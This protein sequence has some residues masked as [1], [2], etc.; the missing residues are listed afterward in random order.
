MGGGRWSMEMW[1]GSHPAII[2]CDVSVEPTILHWRIEDRNAS[3]EFFF[4]MFPRHGH[5]ILQM[6]N[7]SKP[8]FPADLDSVDIRMRDFN[9]LGGMIMRW[10]LMYNEQ[11]SPSSWMW[12]YYP[13]GDIWQEGLK[14]HGEEK[15]FQE[16]AGKYA[17]T[18]PST[19]ILQDGSSAKNE[20]AYDPLNCKTMVNG[21]CNDVDSGA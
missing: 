6:F 3:S 17:P 19:N 12:A 18:S 10:R 9:L 16:L 5:D 13:D 4:S 20:S 1:L 21:H 14:E 8:D 11:P 15:V 7:H 2:P